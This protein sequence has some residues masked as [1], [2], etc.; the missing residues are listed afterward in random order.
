MDG[1]FEKVLRMSLENE[2]GKKFQAERISKRFPKIFGGG[3][4]I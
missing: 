4:K 1:T 2:I 3:T